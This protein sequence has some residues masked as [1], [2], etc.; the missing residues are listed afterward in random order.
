MQLWYGMGKTA[1]HHSHFGDVQHGAEE[2][3]L[4]PSLQG[5]T[6]QQREKAWRSL[7]TVT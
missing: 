5:A 1:S 4:T 6:R 3:F 7:A 2:L